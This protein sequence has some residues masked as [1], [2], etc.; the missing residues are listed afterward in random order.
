MEAVKEGADAMKPIAA[1][2]GETPLKGWREIAGF[3][4]RDESTAR[5]WSETRRLPVFRTSGGG[6]GVPVHAFASELEAWVRAEATRGGMDIDE[7]ATASEDSDAPAAEPAAVVAPEAKANARRLAL[8]VAASMIF[9]FCLGS[10]AT[11]AGVF[12]ASHGPSDPPAVTQAETISETARDLYTRGSFLWTRRTPEGVAEAIPLLQQAVEIQPD[13]AEAH[14]A[15]AISYILAQ[16]YAVMSGWDAFPKA[17]RAALR[18][19]ALNRGLPLAQSAL[20]Y[21]ELQWHWDA[22]ASLARFE[23]TLQEHPASADAHFWFANALLLVGRAEDA[24]P[25]IIRAEEIDPDSS[26]IRNL[27]AHILFFAG[28]TDE[29]L[30][31]LEEIAARY[32]A[33]PMPQ[34]TMYFIRLSQG[35]YSG[36][37]DNYAALGERLGLGHYHRAAEARRAALEQGGVEAMAIAM[38]EVALA[39][40]QRGEALAWDVAHHYAIAGRPEEALSWLRISRNRHEAPLIG[41]GI[42]PA[43]NAL[44]SNPDFRDLLEQIDLPAREPILQR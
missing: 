21:I 12:F 38:A 22:R 32:P 39:A 42:D 34:Y 26:A 3:L 20:A 2:A 33:Y 18:A 13:Y 16:R 6:R 36:F 25:L 17:E 24:L 19:V 30:E 28:R 15:L 4:G 44:R 27:H 8:A 1:K 37:L 29:S 9:G 23:R 7:P 43:F 14:A 11:L 41:L 5:R 35:D 10:L 40:E 31:L